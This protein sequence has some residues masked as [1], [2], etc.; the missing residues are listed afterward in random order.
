MVQYARFQPLPQQLQHPPITD[1]LSNELH[2]QVVVDSVVERFDVQF[3]DPVRTAIHTLSQL[4][5]GLVC[6]ALRSEPVRARSEVGFKDRLKHRLR[7][8]LAHAISNR[9]EDDLILPLLQVHS[10]IQA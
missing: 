9:R 1:T 8:C 6:T 3:H 4:L 10:G 5:T 7:G 2:E